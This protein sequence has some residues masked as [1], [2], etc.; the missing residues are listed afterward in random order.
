[1]S[2]PGVRDAGSSAAEASRRRRALSARQPSISARVATV[3]SHVRGCCGMPSSGHCRNAAS[4]ASW[5]ASSHASN[6]P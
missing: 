2:S 6:W 5:T 3:V 1:M 4:N